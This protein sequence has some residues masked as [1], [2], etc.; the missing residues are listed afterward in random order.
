MTK[1]VNEMTMEEI[2]AAARSV[3]DRVAR[4]READRLA[5]MG[6]KPPKTSWDSSDFKATATRVAAAEARRQ[7]AQAYP[8]KN[9]MDMSQDEYE[10]ELAAKGIYL[11][12]PMGS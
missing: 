2:M 6:V 3:D 11:P 7:A 4:A 8:A 1:N 9:A 10:R 12:K 5:K